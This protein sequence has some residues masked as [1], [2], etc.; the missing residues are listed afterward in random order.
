M[1]GVPEA[2]FLTGSTV[3][4]FIIETDSADPDFDQQLSDTWAGLPPGWEEGI[5]GAV[6]LGQGYLY[7]FRGT[8][9]VRVPYETREV[10]AGYPLP[11]SGNWAGLAFETID[12]VMNWGDGKLYFFCGAQYARYDLPGDRQDPGYPKAIAAGWSG[13]DPSW[14]GTGLDGVLNPG[15]GHAYFFK[16]TQYV[17]VDWGTKRQDGVPQAVSEQWAGLV[18]PY[19]AVWSAAASAPSKVGDFVARYGSY[20]DASE[21]ATGVPALVT[22][23][24]AALESGWGEKAPGNN[25]FGVKAKASDPPETRQLVRTHE[26]LSRPDVPFPEVISVTPRADGTY[27][28]DVRDWFRVYASPEES[29]SAHGNFL[30][31][32]GRY[33]PAFDHTDDPY[34]FARAVASAG[35]A[36]APTYYDVLASTMRSIA[37][38]R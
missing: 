38:H 34:A 5:D 10:E 21:T 36:S 8:E 4:T 28:Y 22:L 35:Y 27:D 19:D 30:R 37:A 14:V 32:N 13:V 1:G 33:A 18:G 2:Y 26:V 9:Y 25:F 24:Q 29:F 6:D 17:S 3:R 20:A 16:G 12:A 11:I 7:V 31:D 15:N 23:G